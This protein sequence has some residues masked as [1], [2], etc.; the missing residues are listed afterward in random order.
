M[1]VGGA[2]VAM[3]LFLGANED[4]SSNNGGNGRGAKADRSV[5]GCSVDHLSLRKKGHD[6]L[7]H[8]DIFCLPGSQRRRLDL[9]KQLVSAPTSDGYEQI[10]SQ[11]ARGSA[12]GIDLRGPYLGEGNY[13]AVAVVDAYRVDSIERHIK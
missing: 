2:L 3:T 12:S 4:G 9:E 6:I 11:P 13:R 5:T 1:T 8:G 7:V 10:D